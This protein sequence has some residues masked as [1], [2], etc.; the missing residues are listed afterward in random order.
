MAPGCSVRDPEQ[1]LLATVAMPVGERL[2][3]AELVELGPDDAPIDVLDRFVTLEHH[4]SGAAGDKIAHELLQQQRARD[5][6][7]GALHDVDRHSHVELA[8]LPQQQLAPVAL[9][10]EVDRGT[11]AVPEPAEGLLDRW[12]VTARGR[13]GSDVVAASLGLIDED[14]SAR[15]TRT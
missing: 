11:P 13:G 7:L 14:R 5:A 1:R 9:L 3:S 8:E 15:D 10:G 4:V 2:E 6:V 12:D